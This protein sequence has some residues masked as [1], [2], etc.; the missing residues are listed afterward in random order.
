M[1]SF[2]GVV[3]PLGVKVFDTSGYASLHE[4]R[5]RAHRDALTADMRRRGWQGPPTVVLADHAISLTG[6]HRRSAAAQAGL[7][8]VPGVS[9]EDLFGACGKD[10]WELVNG[11]EEYATSYYYDFSRLINDH[12]PETVIESYG[13][14][15][16]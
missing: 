9:L 7:D 2:L 10:M 11:S 8:E 14:D 16:Q 6:V 13:L 3:N 12:L 5:D 4:V 15:M 1:R